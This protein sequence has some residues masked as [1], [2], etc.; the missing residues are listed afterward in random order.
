MLYPAD[1]ITKYIEI[2]FWGA[3][4]LGSRLKGIKLLDSNRVSILDVGVTTP[5]SGKCIKAKLGENERIVGVI[6]K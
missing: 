4:D 5:G 1:S 3:T 6:S 2:Y